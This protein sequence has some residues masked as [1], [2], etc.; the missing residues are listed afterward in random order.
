[1][2]YK[3]FLDT[4]IYDESS[5]SFRNGLFSQLREH[6]AT[7]ILELQINSIVEG[8]VRRHIKKNIGDRVRDLNKAIT[9]RELKI[10]QTMEVFS[11]HLKIKDKDQWIDAAQNEFTLLL[12]DCHTERIE[13]PGS[14]I[15]EIFSDYFSCKFPFE[16][17]KKDEFPDA[18][19]IQSIM[20]RINSLSNEVMYYGTGETKFVF[21]ETKT[22]SGA[23][24]DLRFCIVSK[25]EGF[26]NAIKEKACDRL[27]NDVF[28][29]KSLIDFLNYVEI[30][31]QKS[32]ELQ[33]EIDNGFAKNEIIKAIK[34]A[35]EDI[36]YE[37]DEPDGE[38]EDVNII[39]QKEIEFKASVISLLEKQDEWATVRL[40]I[41]SQHEATLHYI[42][43]DEDNS[44]WN[45]I[46]KEYIWIVRKEKI[47]K[48][49]AK[50][51]LT[52]EIK[53]EFDEEGEPV[54]TDFKQFVDRPYEIEVGQNDAINEVYSGIFP[55]RIDD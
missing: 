10:F 50:G 44:I 14:N 1:M 15:E 32:K 18:F 19:I 28:F 38:V 46:K 29:F 40:L 9:A 49:S 34:D 3:V 11:E 22:K 35:I 37:V 39:D 42:Y 16:E 8:E 12:E 47:I 52:I 5:Y 55:N 27:N 54:D 21:K 7:G 48:F 24:E 13:L 4:N 17:A 6:A 25:D 2:H 26:M 20:A 43:I 23:I 33:E 30:Q 41:D 51:Q 36:E 45:Y 53:V 31:N